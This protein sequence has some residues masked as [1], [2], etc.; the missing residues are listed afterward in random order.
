MKKFTL[1]IIAVCLHIGYVAAQGPYGSSYNQVLKMIGAMDETNGPISHEDWHWDNAGVPYVPV[2]DATFE[3]DDFN[4]YRIIAESDFIGIYKSAAFNGIW[5]G[6]S[7]DYTYVGVERI[8]WTDNGWEQK[9]ASP[10]VLEPTLT[11]SVVKDQ[12][13]DDLT[14]LKTLN[15]AGNDFNSIQIIG[16]ERMTSLET[17]DLSNDANGL[18][19][20]EI[21]GCPNLKTLNVSATDV[22]VAD[23]GLLF[24][25]LNGF[26]VTTTNSYTYAPQGTV[27]LSFPVNN[28]DLST[29]HAIGTTFSN[30][31]TQPLSEANGIFSF[32]NALVGQVVTVNLNNS[33]FPALTN[34]VVEITL[35]GGEYEIATPAQLDAVRNDLGGKYTLIDNIDLTDYIAANY[36]AEGWLPIGDATTPFTGTFDGN[37]H[38][39]SGLT[40]NRPN[41]TF[42]GLFG[43]VG[44]CRYLTDSD[45]LGATPTNPST[46]A[47]KAGATIKDLA[48][49]GATISGGINVGG[50]AGALGNSV[51]TGIYV[52]ATITAKNESGSGYNV[53]G[54]AGSF[55]GK[56]SGTLLQDCYTTGKVYGRRSVGGVLGSTFQ[57]DATIYINRIYSTADVRLLN[58]YYKSAVAGVIGQYSPATTGLVKINSS[59]AIND[60]IIGEQMK[61]D[62]RT[63]RFIGGYADSS[64]S[65]VNYS[66]SIYGLKTTKVRLYNHDGD[67]QS[68]WYEI[69]PNDTIN[70][71][72]T[73]PASRLARQKHGINKTAKQ[74]IEQ[75]TYAMGSAKAECNWDFSETWTMG[76]DCYPLPVLK[77]I[78]A[79]KQ[80]TEYPEHLKFDVT[81]NTSAGANGSIS[82]HTGVKSGEPLTITVT[83]DANYQVDAFTVNGENK[84]SELAGT[85]YTITCVKGDYDIEVTFTTATGIKNAATGIAI[86]PT[87]T[88]DVVSISGKAADAVVSVY[89]LSGRE[90]FSTTESNVNLSGFA[91]GVYFVKVTDT[92]TKIIKK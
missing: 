24:S 54:I 8:D 91:T 11:G 5:G 9:P 72:N 42:V 19:L 58:G 81:I 78:K 25:T 37:G 2:V 65:P 85:N 90:L 82:T 33:S 47:S 66:D 6:A 12:Q 36:P 30:W 1:L 34:L 39:I 50:L 56:I 70:V 15:L 21:S 49:V 64:Q 45:N 4:G 89:D 87:V 48:I 61:G 53:G 77:K 80:P 86:Y 16:H 59:F 69:D 46:E 76:N 35:T 75:S 67:Y 14:F 10:I 7:G 17:V 73:Y 88:N 62:G 41:A 13:R 32:S 3:L 71:V 52:D 84:K 68:K 28:V 79:D 18:D 31:S 63:G 57:N 51:I 74:L 83:P 40:I 29:E 60:T 22:S 20:F 92:V 44:F 38:V 26:N 43:Q 27:K 55:W 23:N